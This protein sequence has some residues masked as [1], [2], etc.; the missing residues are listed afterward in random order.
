FSLK[1]SMVLQRRCKTIE[2]F[3][4][5]IER[6]GKSHID[7][8]KEITDLSGLRIILYYVDD[9]DKVCD[10]IDREFDVDVTKSID[11][12]TLLAPDQFGYLS[13]HK[14]VSLSKN[15]ADLPEWSLYKGIVAEIQVRT[16][17]QHAWSAISHILLYKR[18]EDIP[19][20]FRRKLI[21]LSGLL[22]M[23]D[24][25]FSVLRIEQERLSVD[26]NKRIAEDRLDI[27]IDALSI[28]QFLDKC[29]LLEKIIKCVKNSGLK[30]MG[31]Y[32]DKGIT[33]LVFACNIAGIKVINTLN[34]ILIEM[35]SKEKDLSSFFKD[36]HIKRTEEDKEREIM[37][38]IEHWLAVLVVAVN[39]KKI[40]KN[41]LSNIGWE[42]TYIDSVIAT[43]SIFSNK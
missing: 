32:S 4:E 20:Q 17:L 26:I 33:Q 18:T 22:E 3:K 11:K 25:N 34:D 12:R 8:F 14:I 36:F 5:K 29:K 31:G 24:E 27:P 42:K 35:V 40:D 30:V 38:T 9:I 43:S 7:P 28:K 39:T 16:V 6:E 2:S 10:L 21:R 23:A 13:V 19:R 41:L 15:R 1:L 37:G